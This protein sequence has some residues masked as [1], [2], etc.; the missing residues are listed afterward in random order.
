MKYLDKISDED[1]VKL[2][3]PTGI[4]QVYELDNKLNAIRHI[5]WNNPHK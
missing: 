5:I 3:I 2:E 1:I 4:P